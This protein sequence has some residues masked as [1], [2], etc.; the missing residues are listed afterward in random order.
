MIRPDIFGCHSRLQ[1]GGN[2][3]DMFRLDVLEKA[4]L[5]ITRLPFSMKIL[6]ANLPRHEGG[7][8]DAQ[9]DVEV[10]EEWDPKAPPSREIHFTPARVLLQS[11]TGVPAFLAR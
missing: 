7:L 11:S 5:N 8:A 10:L 9:R 2:S 4:G 6:L 3:Y 1:V